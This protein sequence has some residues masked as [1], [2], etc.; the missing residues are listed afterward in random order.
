MAELTI[1]EFLGWYD[2]DTPTTEGL[3]EAAPESSLEDEYNNIR[4]EYDTNGGPASFYE[5]SYD[6]FK[7]K[8]PLFTEKVINNF[9][10][11]YVEVTPEELNDPEILNAWQTGDLILDSDWPALFDYAD[12]VIGNRPHQ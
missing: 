4:A 6:E 8:Y 5:L 11:K 7:D 12:R 10:N 2:D 1:G 3:L 9:L